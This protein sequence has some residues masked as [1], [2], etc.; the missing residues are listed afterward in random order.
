M[1]YYRK[2]VYSFGLFLL[3]LSLSLSIAFS[4][5][6]LQYNRKLAKRPNTPAASYHFVLIPEEMDNDYW[7]LVEKGARAAEKKLPVSIEYNGPEQADIETHLKKID[8]A[9]ASKVDGIITQGLN[10]SQFTPLINKAIA[11]GIPVITIDTDAPNSQRIAYIGTDNYL[12]GYLAGQALIKGTHGQAVVGIITGRFDAEHQKLRV[13]G[14]RDAVKQAPGIRIAAVE[15]SNITRIEAAEKASKI[16]HEH[17]DVTAFY[18]TSALD[19]IGIAQVVEEIDDKSFYIIGFDTLPETLDLLKRGKIQ[20]TVVQTPYEMGY[21]SVK[22]MLDIIKGKR[23]STVNHT[24]TKVIGK[25]D[26]PLQEATVEW[27]VPAP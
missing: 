18:G 4:A 21:K 6:A 23:V 9:I 20:A 3:I 19:A 8:M 2:W 16:L 22:L 15:E 26:L 25:E 13:Q 1:A 11:K 14:F 10:E 7:R 17:P 24:E 5:K 27:S 12:S